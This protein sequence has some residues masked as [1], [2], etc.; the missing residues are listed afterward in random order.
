[1]YL[2]KSANIQSD[3]GDSF[4]G[5][6][7]LSTTVKTYV[8]ETPQRKIAIKE[9]QVGCVRSIN[10]L[11]ILTN[12]NRILLIQFFIQ[13]PTSLTFVSARVGFGDQYKEDLDCFKIVCL[14]AVETSTKCDELYK[15]CFIK[16]FRRSRSEFG[17]L[18]KKVN[19]SK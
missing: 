10:F 5:I 13:T 7:L 2:L 19:F 6:K 15:R 8:A 14:C 3:G 17:N 16:H 11:D 9:V 1:M 12:T 18:I 4:S